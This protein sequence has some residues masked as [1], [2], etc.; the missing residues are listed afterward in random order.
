MRL[1]D[2][3]HHNRFY[4]LIHSDFWRFELSVWLHVVALS[5]VSIFIPILLLNLGFSI[6][7]IIIYYLIYHLIDTPF[8]FLARKF[9]VWW[10]ARIVIILATIFAILFFAILSQLTVTW[11]ALVLLAFVGAI[12]DA[13]YWV[14][15]LFLFMEANDD[16]GDSG[17]ETSFLYMARRFG[18]LLGPAIGGLV[19]IFSGQNA[20]LLTSI[21]IFALSVVP[22][23]GARHLPD[24]PQ[25]PILSFKE[26]FKD[27]KE[28]RNYLYTSLQAIHDSAELILWPLFI[29][30]IFGTIESV[31]ALPIIVSISAIL[32]T[33]FAGNF[34]RQTRD[35]L[36]AVGAAMI[37][38][39]WVMRMV[40]SEPL[41]L[42]L[43]VFLAGLFSLLITIP[44]DS[45][46]FER[47]KLMDPLS[48]A[49]YRN[50]FRMGVRIIFFGALALLLNVFNISFIIAGASMVILIFLNYI[51]LQIAK[52]S[53][54]T[55]IAK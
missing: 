14:S 53:A 44:I 43:S 34:D 24:K 26:F 23:L 48:A 21:I 49:T 13:F 30:I 45:R 5:L 1:F 9:V 15:H 33:Y 35:N 4:K 41:L 51:F 54:R 8:N 19:L 12:Y 6:G 2:L 27:T 18:S 47:G 20:L 16:D 10:G 39:V 46:I 17:K 50:T 11:S 37:A 36:I 28:K 40:V 52:K 7:D 38:L 29:F 25:K 42:Y 3:Y 31:A 22:L 32:F 55:V